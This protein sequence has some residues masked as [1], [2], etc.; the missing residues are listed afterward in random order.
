MNKTEQIRKLIEITKLLVRSGVCPQA[1]RNFADWWKFVKFA[2]QKGY[3]YVGFD[4]DGDIDIVVVGYKVENLDE[5]VGKNLPV[6]ESGN[7]LY[8]P[9]LTSRS[10]DRLKMKK[11]LNAYL[12]NN[13]SVHQIA[14]RW[15]GKFNDLRTKILRRSAHV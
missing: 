13:P 14:Y 11:M 7:I 6:N 5:S 4:A 3:L 2:H 15:R 12:D 10:K 8:V 9:I 1:S